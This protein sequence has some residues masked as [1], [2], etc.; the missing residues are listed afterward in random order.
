MVFVLRE[1]SVQK[2]DEDSG[3]SL[4]AHVIIHDTICNYISM[5]LFHY[6]IQSAIEP[7]WANS[8]FFFPRRLQEVAV[9]SQGFSLLE[10]PTWEITWGL[11][12]TGYPCRTSTPQSSTALWICT[13]SP[14]P[15]IQRSSRVTYW[16]WQ[17]ACWPAVSTQRKRYSSSS[18][19]WVGH[20]WLMPFINIYDVLSLLCSSLHSMLDAYTLL[21]INEYSQVEKVLFICDN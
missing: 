7:S 9:Y 3:T 20:V 13:P 16:T 6:Q 11:W 17:P 10:C 19:R 21:S 14:S 12:R 2:C 1:T 8:F 5:M 15:R 4:I 18:L